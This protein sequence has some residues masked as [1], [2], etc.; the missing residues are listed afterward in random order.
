MSGFNHIFQ[1]PVIHRQAAKA[2]ILLISG[3]LISANASGIEAEP[4]KSRR[5]EV[6]ALSQNYWDTKYGHT[7]DEIVIQLLPNN[8]SKRQALKQDI[9]RLN[10][11]AFINKD[12]ARL[13][14]NKRLWMPG[15][16]KQADNKVDPATTIVERYS[17]GNIKRPR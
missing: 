6:Y 11:D 8:P 10:P 12:P 7:L 13:L 9:V 15:Y 3:S 2:I 5:I 16:M 17:W 1:L 4:T 14:A